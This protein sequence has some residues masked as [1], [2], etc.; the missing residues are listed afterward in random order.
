ML[1]T[2]LAVLVLSLSFGANSSEYSVVSV[3]GDLCL[4]ISILLA[5]GYLFY[6]RANIFLL[7]ASILLSIYPIIMMSSPSFLVFYYYW[8]YLMFIGAIFLYKQWKN[9]VESTQEVFKKIEK[10][11]K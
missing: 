5:L 7:F 2:F 11:F 3:S 1:R 8:V 10:W 6:E 9:I 4:A